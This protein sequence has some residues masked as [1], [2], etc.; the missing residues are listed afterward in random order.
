MAQRKYLGIG[1]KYPIE[2]SSTGAVELNS[3]VALVRQSIV[4]I[5]ETKK[6][7]VFNNRSFGSDVRDLLFEP[8][9][10]ILFSLLDYHV[11]E[12][13]RQSEK[14]VANVSTEITNNS[15]ESSRVDVKIKYSILA[16]NEVDSFIFPFYREV[17]L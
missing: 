11:V 8:N 4:R 15:S 13:I 3:D 6:G 16:S 10:S 9:D 12:G 17:N 5:L 2:I 1:I 14:R 7:S